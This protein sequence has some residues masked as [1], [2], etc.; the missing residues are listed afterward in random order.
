MAVRPLES[1]VISS[2]QSVWRMHDHAD[3]ADKEFQK[4]RKVVL[5]AYQNTC[6]YCSHQSE[7]FQ[8]GHHKD[9][10]HNNNKLGNI[11]CAC[12]LCHQVF[13]PGLA[14][15][16]EGC[17]LV[18]V[19]ELSQAE[20][21]QLAL[22][23]WLINKVDVA[24]MVGEKAIIITRLAAKAKALFG[25]LENR[26][27]TVVLRLKQS[28]KDPIFKFSPDLIDKIKISHITPTLLSNV[29][30]SLDKESYDN[31]EKLLGGIRLLPKATR[32]NKRINFWSDE[33]SKVTPVD[34]WYEF[35]PEE[36][37]VFLIDHVAGKIELLTA[38]PTEAG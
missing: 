16:K 34:S 36:Q 37:V 20:V 33:Q 1:L 26:R 8:E 4:I 31:R 32:F 14:G 10:D 17:D 21:N 9:D 28:L 5:D 12:P 7:K 25:L 29:L 22:T 6:A 30:L 11:A 27:G 38:K 23:I 3:D 2:K 24:K 19:P 15:M 18:Y 13:H 35:L